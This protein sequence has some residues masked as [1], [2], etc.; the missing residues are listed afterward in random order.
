MGLPVRQQPQIYIDADLAFDLIKKGDAIKLAS[1]LSRYP[2]P[3][4]TKNFEE[5]YAHRRGNPFN[6]HQLRDDIEAYWTSPAMKESAKAMLRTLQKWNI[7]PP[8]VT[9][10]QATNIALEAKWPATAR[11]AM[12]ERLKQPSQWPPKY[13]HVTLITRMQEWG[14]W[15]LD[16]Y[17]Y[18][19]TSKTPGEIGL[20]FNPPS[21][22][23]EKDAD[24][25][26][27]M[28]FKI[29][30][31]NANARLMKICDKGPYFMPLPSYEHRT[32]I[33]KG[34]L[35]TLRIWEKV[36]T[37]TK[38]KVSDNMRRTIQEKIQDL[39]QQKRGVAPGMLK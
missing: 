39:E 13:Q 5:N 23:G 21:Q 1:L 2:A 38:G 11:A 14:N 32:T 31:D 19:M 17:H 26:A 12:R 6:K 4:M 10:E 16:N 34:C 15:I 22:G 18:L 30:I 36:F 20:R 37:E 24:L 35:E 3:V 25:E 28:N 29:I 27:I 33:S 8:K 7:L 9:Y